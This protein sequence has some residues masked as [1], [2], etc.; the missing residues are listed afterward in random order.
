MV[1]EFRDRMEK[2]LEE[3]KSALAKAK[4]DMARYYNQR[5]IPAPEYHV[6]D[7]V[8]L[9]ALDIRTM[10][11]SRK[12][13]HRYLGPYV[14]QSRVGKHSYKLQLPL[15]MSRLHPVFNVVKLIPAPEDPIPGRRAKPPPPPELV[16]GEEH[17]VVEK[18]LDSRFMRGQ[19]HFLVKWEGYGYEE[20][21]WVAEEDM[22]APAKVR[23]FY[24]SHPGAPRR[25][26][27]MAFESL[28]PRASR[29]RPP[30]RGGDGG[31]PPISTPEPSPRRSTRPKVHRTKTR[32]Q[33]RSSEVTPRSRH[34]IH[35]TEHRPGDRTTG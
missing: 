22:A 2:S 4:D 26:R 8:F 35:R 1:N 14:I 19:L 31:G 32:T 7:R 18:V 29:M 13:G 23:E 30:R 25:I 27:S 9:G 34:E 24:Q 20:N 33:E 6:G 15:S 12:L 21:T 10:R 5:R 17:Y 16:D 3:A 28:M 11:P